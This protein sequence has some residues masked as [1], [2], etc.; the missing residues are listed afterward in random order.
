MEILDRVPP[1]NLEAEQA[2][3]GA[4]LLA[5]D[6]FAVVSEILWPE[7]FYGEGHRELYITL[8]EMAEAGR[9]IDLVTVTEELQHREILDKV[10]GATYLAA[11]AGAVPT[12]VNAGYYAGI[13]AEKGLLRSLINSCT[14]LAAQ[15]YEDGVESEVLLDDAERMILP[16]SQKRISRSY[17][18]I[19]ELLVETLEKIEQLYQ[20]KG[21]VTGF[22]TGF[23]DIDK[24]TS[25]LQ[26]SD[27][28][29]LAARP[30][31][32]KTALGLNIAQNMA[33]KHQIPV[34][35]F[36]LEMSGDQV[37]QRLLC[38]ESL[39]D[40]HRLRT[41]FLRE[42]DWP[43][44]LKAA[45]RLSEAPIFIDDTPALTLMEMRSKAR[46]LKLEH[47]VGMLMVDY[48]QLMQTGKR[49]ENRVQ[50]ISEISRFLKSLARELD[51][52]VLALSQ[53]SR[54]V[55]Q[56]GGDRRP[57]LSDLRESGSL[58]QDS[59]VVMFIYRDEYYDKDSEDKGVADIIIAKQRNG[60]TGTI[61]LAFLKEYTKF[62]NLEKREPPE[63]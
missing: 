44:L 63:E 23:E 43:R 11:L 14:Q 36:S 18:S 1:H 24:Y 58:E 27:L 46:R 47:G 19:R 56:R 31:M 32:G 5:P 8:K 60:P 37:V 6:T 55:E 41:G 51:V 29:L 17:R 20:K 39:V 50:E 28:I 54:A 15:G 53:L 4:L 2:V 3:L 10:G 9:P 42:D 57:I 25:G 34:G 30:S 12:A 26:P 49:S 61:Q 22:P 13:V 7:S 52:P 16:L 45:T 38:S 48:L 21:G 62:V 33:V 59:D 35:I 40:Q